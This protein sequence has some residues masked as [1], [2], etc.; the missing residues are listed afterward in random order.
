MTKFW[1]ENNEI[2]CVQCRLGRGLPSYQV[3]PWSNQPFRHNRHGLKRGTRCCV[4]IRVEGGVGSHLIQCG[5]GRGLPPYQVAYWPIK[6]FGHNRHGGKSGGAVP[7]FRGGE[8]G[9]HL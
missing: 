6:P 8:L 1:Y 9:T 2:S 5:L 7:H 4:P 3:A